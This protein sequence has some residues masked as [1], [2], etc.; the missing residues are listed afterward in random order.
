MVFVSS[1]LNSS[2]LFASKNAVD[3]MISLGSYTDHWVGK[4]DNTVVIHRLV[5]KAGRSLD[6]KK[7]SQSSKCTP[8]E[9][10]VHM[11]EIYD[12]AREDLY[13]ISSQISFVK[14]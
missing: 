5:L 3:R 12:G 10:L 13:K 14:R 9:L 1:A 2:L 4:S 8:V 6:Q 7:N 11:Q